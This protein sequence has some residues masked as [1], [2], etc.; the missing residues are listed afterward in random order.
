MENQGIFVSGLIKTPAGNYTPVTDDL[1]KEL[2][3]AAKFAQLPN[4]KAFING[5]QVMSFD[6]IQGQKISGLRDIPTV[7]NPGDPSPA[8]GAA[9]SIRLERYDKAGALSL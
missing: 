6:D 9:P 4:F 5:N 8:A 7:T 3:E 2:K 1:V